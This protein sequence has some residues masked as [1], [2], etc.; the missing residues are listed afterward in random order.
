AER[1]V[2]DHWSVK[3]LIR[4]IVLSRA[5]ATSSQYDE[6]RHEL[7]PDNS[8]LWRHSPRPLDAEALRDAI[9]A[10]GGQLDLN[11]P[12][13]SVVT[14]FVD[15]LV[16]DNVRPDLFHVAD[17]HRS[18]YL[19]ILRNAEPELLSLF[20]FPDPSLIIG[21]RT[22]TTVPAQTLFLLN[23]R[24]VVEQSRHFARRLLE[25]EH[26]NA[27]Q[28]EDD[29]RVEQGYKIALGRKPTAE[30]TTRA[31]AYIRELKE[32]L[33]KSEGAA[34]AKVSPELAAWAGFCQ[35]LLASAEFRYVE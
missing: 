34:K 10:A 4:S 20:D 5:Y 33:A 3:R 27:K 21:A 25:A 12:H 1:F 26:A 35:A 22:E 28:S 6:A 15:V 13:G 19:P 23:S 9:L 31:M 7:D 29:A 16:G 17:N 14:K 2:E 32:E 30:E 24:F 18:I 11:P 8:L